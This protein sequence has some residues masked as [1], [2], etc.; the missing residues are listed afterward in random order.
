MF[1]ITLYMDYSEFNAPH[2]VAKAKQQRFEPFSGPKRCCLWIQ[3]RYWCKESSLT[4]C[5]HQTGW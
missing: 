5:G 1:A 3:C 2:L 4:S